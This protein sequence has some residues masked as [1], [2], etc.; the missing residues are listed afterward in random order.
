MNAAS[1][2][3]TPIHPNAAEYGRRM[4]LRARPL[5]REQLREFHRWISPLVRSRINCR[6]VTSC[7][8]GPARRPCLYPHFGPLS[9]DSRHGHLWPFSAA[10][11]SRPVVYGG[12]SG[13]EP[14]FA[15]HSPV[16]AGGGDWGVAGEYTGWLPSVTTRAKARA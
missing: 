3:P 2:V 14:P 5:W 11:G 10:G 9:G 4:G 13:H 12:L 7:W 16:A 15:S 8:T 1:T 6:K